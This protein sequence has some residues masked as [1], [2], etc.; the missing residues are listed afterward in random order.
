MYHLS[1]ITSPVF[2]RKGILSQFFGLDPDHKDTISDSSYFAYFERQIRLAGQNDN[3]GDEICTPR[4]SA[5]IVARLKAGVPRE[6]I[7]KDLAFLLGK[8]DPGEFDTSLENAIDFVAR[9]YLMVHVGTISRGVT[10]QKGIAWLDGT[11]GD[12]LRNHF[13]HQVILTDSV[14]LER[15]FNL[16]SIDRI[17]DVSIQWTPNLVDHLRF[18]EDGKKPVL[19]VFHCA[20]FLEWQRDK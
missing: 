7:R 8:D 6:V 5:F 9:L 20:G 16:Q 4:N 10:G 1:P 15:I 14:K 3:S 13:Q 12:A 17:A 19:N 2:Q 18:I 11:L